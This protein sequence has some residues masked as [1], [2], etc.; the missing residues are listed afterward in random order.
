MTAHPGV[1]ACC[2]EVLLLYIYEPEILS[3]SPYLR[4]RLGFPDLFYVACVT[5]EAERVKHILTLSRRYSVV[6]TMP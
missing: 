4:K 5:S 3:L 1:L 6:I 2:C